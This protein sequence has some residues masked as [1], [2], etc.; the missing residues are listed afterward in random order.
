MT[1]YQE[2]LTRVLDA[3]AI[4]VKA[5]GQNIREASKANDYEWVDTVTVECGIT[6]D[7]IGAAFVTSQAQVTA[8][9]SRVMRLHELAQANNITLA[10]SDGTK[11]GVMQMATRKV[12]GTSHSEIEVINAFA[13]Y[14]K[15][16]DEWTGEW[17]KLPQRDKRTADILL[18]VGVAEHSTGILRQGVR[19]FGIQ[20]DELPFFARSIRG[21]SNEVHRAYE[22]ELAGLGVI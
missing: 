7:L 5:A 13:N 6:E 18:A 15:H 10:T 3:L 21:W 20:F 8:I 1:T 14:F 17:A 19:A 4:G 22:N 11:T 9:V 16:N 12:M 2:S